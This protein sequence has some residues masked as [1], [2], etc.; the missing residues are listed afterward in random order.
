M[1]ALGV[2]NAESYAQPATCLA[3]IKT[4]AEMLHIKVMTFAKIVTNIQNVLFTN[5]FH[6]VMIKKRIDVKE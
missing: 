4:N 2:P 6:G 1:L 5:F 3:T